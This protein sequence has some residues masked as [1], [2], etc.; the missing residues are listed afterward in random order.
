MTTEGT[1]L[2]IRPPSSFTTS[3]SPPPMPSLRIE[4]WTED[5]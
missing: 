3:H 1:I 5:G 4:Y 2:T